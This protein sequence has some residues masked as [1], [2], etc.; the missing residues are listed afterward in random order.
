MCVCMCVRTYAHVYT[1]LV[2]AH[3]YLLN[4]HV[5]VC[6]ICLCMWHVHTHVCCMRTHVSYNMC[7]LVPMSM[8]MGAV[9]RA[10]NSFSLCLIPLRHS[11]NLELG[12]LPASPSDTFV[13]S[14][15]STGVTGTCNHAWVF[16]WVLEIWTQVL[17]I[18]LQ[19]F[20]LT[21]PFP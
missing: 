11:Q 1:C 18:A 9:T 3:V 12:W 5:C 14:H 16:M 2:C 15:H 17:M 20:L 7:V 8:S 13:I 10:G 6:M 19:V 21:K 4:T